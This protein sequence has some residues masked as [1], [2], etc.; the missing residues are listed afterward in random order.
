MLF[1]KKNEEVVFNEEVINRPLTTT[2]YS[3]DH[4]FVD[5]IPSVTICPCTYRFL[6]HQSCR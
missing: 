6:S 5:D 3:N 1:N 4:T 2:K